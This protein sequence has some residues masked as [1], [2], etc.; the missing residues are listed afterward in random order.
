[1]FKILSSLL[2]LFVLSLS[3][4]EKSYVF[5]AKGKFAED[6]KALVEKYSKD[7][8]VN[9]KVYESKGQETRTSKSKTQ[10]ILSAFLNDDAEALKYADVDAG[11]ILYQKS[12]A[13]CHGVNADQNS[14]AV[15]HKLSQLKPIE[16]LELLQGY[17]K[18]Y[19]GQFGGSLRYIMKPHA[20]NLTSEEMQSIA[21]Y[22][23]SL[24]H[25][26]KVPTSENSTQAIEEQETPTSYL[27]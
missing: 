13:S 12:C 19:D 21:V 20:D 22:I 3:A 9:V 11:R 4:E 14:Y 8:K 17:Q 25:D 5:E 18:N 10:T 1:M 26:T 6:L 24:S 15:P 2:L 16:T 27:Q 7:G 23:Y